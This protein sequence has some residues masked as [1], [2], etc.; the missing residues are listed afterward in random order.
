MA[1]IM[2]TDERDIPLMLQ[3]TD[4]T[5][6]E[7]TIDGPYQWI[8]TDE[9]LLTIMPSEDGASA[10]I[11]AVG[12]TGSVGIMVNAVIAKTQNKFGALLEVEIMD[13]NVTLSH[14][15]KDMPPQSAIFVIADSMATA[16]LLDITPKTAAK[17]GKK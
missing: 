8:S 3:F 11:S 9:N 14:L 13:V 6:K 2:T 7:E 16:D 1:F 4:P 10:L 17:K 15:T 12:P 5:G